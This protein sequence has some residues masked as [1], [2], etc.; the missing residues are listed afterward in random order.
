MIAVYLVDLPGTGNRKIH[1]CN[2]D[3]ENE[4]DALT[5]AK[6][7]YSKFFNTLKT[8]SFTFKFEKIGKSA[9][10]WE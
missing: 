2:V 1:I 7:K 5:F 9:F 8:N 3:T 10:N 6:K 4:G